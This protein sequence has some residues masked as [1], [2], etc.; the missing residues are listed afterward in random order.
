MKERNVADIVL[1]PKRQVTLP[2]EI[3]DQLSIEPGDVLELTVEDSTLIAKPR[4]IVAL[5]ALNEI[6]EAFRRSGIT[7]EKLLKTVHRIRQEV[8]MERYGVKT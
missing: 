1:R 5:E 7:K 4:K 3:C 6:E 2:R 8:A